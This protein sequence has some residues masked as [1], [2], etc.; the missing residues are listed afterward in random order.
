MSA[1]QP[2][3]GFERLLAAL[4]RDLLEATDEEI[5]AVANELG[6]KP[7][8]KGSIALF[9]VTFAARLNLKGHKPKRQSKQAS[10]GASVSRSRRRPKGDTPSST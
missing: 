9:G 6:M 1:A 7:A 3:P 5:M 4:E 2:I 8:M 10:G